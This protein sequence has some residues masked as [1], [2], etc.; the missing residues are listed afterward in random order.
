MHNQF[1]IDMRCFKA[2]M[3]CNALLALAGEIV[4][5]NSAT[6]IST[7][8]QRFMPLAVGVILPPLQCRRRISKPYTYIVMVKK[9]RGSST[10]SDVLDEETPVSLASSRNKLVK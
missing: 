4:A 10:Q 2:L 5:H 3:T 8:P 9:S 7:N 1:W 6:T